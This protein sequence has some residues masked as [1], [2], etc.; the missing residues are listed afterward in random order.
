MMVGVLGRCLCPL[1]RCFPMKVV[2]T[3]VQVG[4]CWRGEA[5][6]GDAGNR[7]SVEV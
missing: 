5:I 3:D 1:K 6:V 2:G 4:L 7:I